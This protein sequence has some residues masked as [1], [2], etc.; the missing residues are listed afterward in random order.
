MNLTK[1]NKRRK[2]NYII[3]RKSGYNS[4]ESNR[5]KDMSRV[6]IEYLVKAKKDFKLIERN[7]AGGKIYE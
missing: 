4:I 3:L 7:I 5:Y 6:K 2:H 1:R